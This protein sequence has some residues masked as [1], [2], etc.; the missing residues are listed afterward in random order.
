MKKHV[1]AAILSMAPVASQAEVELGFYSGW[2][3]APHSNVSGFDPSN[4]VDT[5]LDF[6]A[7]WYGNSLSMPPYYGL[8]ATWWGTGVIGF[9][10]EFTHAKVYSDDATRADNGFQVL[11]FTDGL[12]ILTVNATRR[13][14]GALNRMT[15]YVGGGVGISVPHVEVQSD[16]PLTFGYQLGGAAVRWYAGST[17]DLT[18]KWSLFAEYQGTYSQNDVDLDG[19]G[20]LSTDIITNAVNLGLSFS[21]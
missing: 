3:T 15:P 16:G 6:A 17:Y 2:Q 7:K 4:P 20:T 1:A 12:N 21:F 19:G 13:W 18:D 14:E 5:D 8:R 10:A 9:G 11:E